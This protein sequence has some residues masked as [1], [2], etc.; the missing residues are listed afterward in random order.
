MNWRTVL[1]EG[2][3]VIIL[4]TL[5]SEGSEADK[6]F[7]PLTAWFAHLSGHVASQNDWQAV[8]RAMCVPGYIAAEIV[9]ATDM[10]DGYYPPIRAALL[11]RYGLVEARR[12]D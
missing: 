11:R 5:P 3:A 12:D 4:G 10:L 6:L 1:G 9:S 2:D 7:C 8:A